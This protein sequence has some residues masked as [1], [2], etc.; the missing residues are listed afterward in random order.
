MDE[1]SQELTTV[2]LASGNKRQIS[3]LPAGRYILRRVVEGQ[4]GVGAYLRVSS[5]RQAKRECS[6]AAQA[7]SIFRAAAEAKLK[8]T[9]LYV[10][11]GSASK[12]PMEQRPGVMA[13]R[14]D[15]REG[16]LAAAFIYRRDRLARNLY[17][18]LNHYRVA[19][20]SNVR[21]VFPADH[22]LEFESCSFGI[23]MEALFG[24]IAEQEAELQGDR[25]RA[26][27][28]ERA[29]SGI[30]P[31]STP[32]VGL[33]RL[34]GGRRVKDPAFATVIELMFKLALEEMLSA[35]QIAS[36]LKAAFPEL[37]ATWSG[38]KVA[39]LLTHPA[40][41]GMI[42]HEG[43]LLPSKD[44]ERYV[45]WEQQKAI[46]SMKDD[47][48]KKSGSASNYDRSSHAPHLLLGVLKCG[49]CGTWL[50]V[51]RKGRRLEEEGVYRCPLCKPPIRIP[52]KAV[53]EAV[54]R[55]CRQRFANISAK[56][57]N[58]LL[59]VN[60]APALAK[61]RAKKQQDEEQLSSIRAAI[62]RNHQLIENEE[63]PHAV[64]AYRQR[65]RE[66]ARVAKETEEQ[67]TAT[68]SAIWRLE[69][70]LIEP[71]VDLRRWAQQLPSDKPLG[72]KRRL[73]EVITEATWDPDSREIRMVCR[74]PRG[75]DDSGPSFIYK[76][77]V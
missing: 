3:K 59:G 66:Q 33:K 60:A 51:P 61:L 35:G 1:Q 8:V 26:A 4:K 76:I 58:E 25:R 10:D 6:L 77:P 39:R 20:T 45:T 9:H 19:T 74:V 29:N 49:R 62:E 41:S 23:L 27:N 72:L 54:D 69:S 55:A 57:L 71:Q 73:R 47:R 37:C 13:L 68:N 44:D 5:R 16:K 56:E 15:I 17:E 38:N 32:P 21:V 30:D 70:S 43:R 36:R 2:T 28:K 7:T 22:L 63:D 14:E 31:S 11:V 18:H 65:L 67:I 52:T 64:E 53:D 46:K 42:E 40:Y 12:L 34:P 48:F 24:Y 75:T 50:K